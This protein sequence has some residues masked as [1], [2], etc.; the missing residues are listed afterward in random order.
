ML[1]DTINCPKDL[2]QLSIAQMARLAEELR[3]LIVKTVSTTGGHLSSNLGI[4][5]LT[6][7]LHHVFNT[8]YDKIVWAAGLYCLASRTGA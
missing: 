5:E 6:L 4:V 8:P 7:A 1:L 3:E 2:R